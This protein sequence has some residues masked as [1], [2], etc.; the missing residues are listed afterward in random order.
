MNIQK[1]KYI[2]K[3]IEKKFVKDVYEEI[4]EHFE[5]TRK[6]YYWKSIKEFI[7][8]I[9]SNSFILDCGCGNGKHMLLRKDCYFNGFDFCA[10]SMKI[11]KNKQL[12][13]L[14]NDVKLIP[15]RNNIFDITLCVAVLHHLECV[16]NRLQ[17]I[18]ELSR[19]T[20]LNGLIYIQVWASDVKKDKKFIKINN[21]N[22]YFVTWFVNKDR[23]IKRYYHLFEKDELISLCKESNL[24]ICQIMNEFNNWI[25]IAKK[26]N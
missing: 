11:C 12:D 23:N 17:A 7:L 14:V 10:N 16:K 5:N 8:N 13:V 1:E 20:K 24:E 22:D 9:P 18:C 19:I 3:K 6:G 4:A 26:I 15:F 21:N 2:S 25:I